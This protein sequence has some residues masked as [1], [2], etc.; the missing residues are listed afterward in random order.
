MYLSHKLSPSGMYLSHKLSPSGMYLSHKLS[1]SGM[2]RVP[3]SQTVSIFFHI[4]QCCGSGMFIPDPTFFHPSSRIRS[5]SIPD[6]GSSSKNLSILTPKK[7]K[8]W[9]LSSKKFDPGCSSRIRILFYY[10][11]RIPH[12]GVKKAPDPGSRIRI[13][14]TDI[15][16]VFISWKYTFPLIINFK[17]CSS[18]ASM[19]YLSLHDQGSEPEVENYGFISGYAHFQNIST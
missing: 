8:K 9:F 12:P 5:V 4:L 17:A 11:S 14:N 19:Y 7:P 3:V 18:E 16:F 1:P 15:L 13:R 6:P 10:P 2:Y